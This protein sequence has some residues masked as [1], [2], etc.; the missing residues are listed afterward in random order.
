MTAFAPAWL[1]LREEADAAARAGEL[2][3]PLRARLP[4]GEPLVIWDL[5]CG[6]GALGRWLA[7]R[8]PGPQHWVLYDGDPALLE[9]ARANAYR[10]ADG[11]PATLET[12]EGDLAGLRAADLVGASL[13]T[14]SALLDVLTAGQVDGIAAAVS[15]PALLTLTVAGR[16]RIVPHDP[17]DAEIGAAFDAH[18]RRDGLLGPDAAAAAATAFRRRGA[19]VQTRPSPWRLGPERAGLTAE[20]LRGWVGAAVEQRPDLAEPA[21]EYL[22]RRLADCDA[23]R[24]TAEVHHI[25]LLALPGGTT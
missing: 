7:P 16:V 21:A 17:L 1:A 8:L 19:T 11:T 20:W 5:G 25:D 15:C 12:R 10:T 13:V 2:L 6:T 14:A 4:A 9:E 24:L 18:Q 23:G 3:G 22:R